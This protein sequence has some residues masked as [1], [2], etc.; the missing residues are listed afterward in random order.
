MLALI[1]GRLKEKWASE[2]GK[3]F[4]KK[5]ILCLNME[6]Y[7]YLKI[8]SFIFTCYWGLVKNPVELFIGFSHF[9]TALFGL[10][11]CSALTLLHIQANPTISNQDTH[12]GFLNTHKIPVY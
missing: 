6:G 2:K 8:A 10:L 11:F 3:G 9:L 5:M 7:V 12:D 4:G 1:L